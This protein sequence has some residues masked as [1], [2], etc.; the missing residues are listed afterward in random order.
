MLG[1]LL[2]IINENDFPGCRSEGDSVLFV[3]DDSDVVSDPDPEALLQRIQHEADLSCEW[4]RDNRM[5][6]AGEKSKL[7]I[8]STE[9]LR[10]S[11][12]GDQELS[13]LVDGKKSY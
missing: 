6:V 13:I 2:F 12:L 9:E 11:R 3:D 1:G 4:L 10:R 5:C 8:V 7:L